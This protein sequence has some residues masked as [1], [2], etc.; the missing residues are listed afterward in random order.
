MAN[1]K[2]T[3][4]PAVASMAA[5]DILAVV[6]SAVSGKITLAN[7]KSSL[8]AIFE[9]QK[10]VRSESV[11]GTA[12]LILQDS[13]GGEVARLK[14]DETTG[15]AELVS[16]GVLTLSAPE[17]RQAGPNVQIDKSTSFT[18]E[19]GHEGADIYINNAVVEIITLHDHATQPMPVNS[20]TFCY[21]EGPGALT[22]EAGGSATI[23]GGNK[24]SNGQGSAFCFWKVASNTW[25]VTGEVS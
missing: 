23:V 12:T 8:A 19:V 5:A 4:L 6:A 2:F 21:H 20:R 17:I 15:E 1:K 18:V 7:L 10:I 25:K 9:N 11:A 16:T 14:Y 24:T 13:G 3:E 22:V